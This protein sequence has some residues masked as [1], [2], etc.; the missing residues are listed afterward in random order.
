MF[1]FTN[2]KILKFPFWAFFYGYVENDPNNP[3]F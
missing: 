2:I 3:I 1:R